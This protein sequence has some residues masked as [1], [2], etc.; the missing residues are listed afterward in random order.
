MNTPCCISGYLIDI[1]LHICWARRGYHSMSPVVTYQEYYSLHCPCQLLFHP[2]RN[3]LHL[4]ISS[5][6]HRQSL[7]MRSHHS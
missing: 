6:V 4:L 7:V 2:P 5:A 1:N 3:P